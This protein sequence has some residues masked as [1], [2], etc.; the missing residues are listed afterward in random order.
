MERGLPP[1]RHNPNPTPPG[2]RPRVAGLRKPGESARPTPRPRSTP[3]EQ[4][5]ETPDSP[6]QPEQDSSAHVEPGPR[7][8]PEH[9]PEP[10]G[11]EAAD[12]PT[13]EPTN[14]PADER[15]PVAET[16]VAE[17]DPRPSPRPKRRSEGSGKPAGEQD[18]VGAAAP[19]TPPARL[20]TARAGKSRR[21]LSSKATYILAAGL[22][23]LAAAFT[24]GAV[25]A[26]MAEG[27]E[28]TALLDVKQTQ[29]V[30][31]AMKS[32][33]EQLFSFDYRNI[34]KT[35]QAAKDLLANKQV[36]K[37][38]STLIDE[39]KRLAPK[40]KIV[41]T[42]TATEAAVVRMQDDSAKVMVYVDQTSTRTGS[43]ETSA[44]GAALW[45]Q[46]ELRDG[47]W[48]VVGMDTYSSGDP[49]DPKQGNAPKPSGN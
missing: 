35:E 39:V 20:R 43:K 36:Q 16:P 33:A 42:V 40:Q 14:E 48:K 28:N 32:A 2:R 46:T 41:V 11:D 13:D 23:V 29:Q 49:M 47:K 34:D 3:S 15:E 18:L 8:E 27:T 9:E 38:Y 19:G 7:P 21:R 25:F 37:K 1:S 26:R 5:D 24:T 12:E 44:G 22:V 10:A 6:A 4:A 17:Q 30:K 45:L 31:K